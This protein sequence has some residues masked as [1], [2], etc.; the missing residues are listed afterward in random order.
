M[1][2]KCL[3]DNQ[4]WDEVGFQIWWEV[5]FQ[6]ENDK[7][8]K[9][10]IWLLKKLNKD[11]ET[12]L[13][14]LLIGQ[15]ILAHIIWVIYMKWSIGYEPY[16]INLTLSKFWSSNPILRARWKGKV[17][18]LL[19]QRNYHKMNNWFVLWNWRASNS[20]ILPELSFGLPSNLIQIEHIQY[21]ERTPW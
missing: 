15:I 11:S 14:N 17:E 12:L 8:W 21:Y 3:I 10:L 18:F 6:V 9:R 16:H 2:I 19:R 1:I 4:W 7:K 5:T 13:S 20:Y